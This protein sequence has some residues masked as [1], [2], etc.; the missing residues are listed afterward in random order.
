MLEVLNVINSSFLACSDWFVRIFTA[1]SMTEVY[2]VA[3]FI[4]FGIRFLLRPIFGTSRG[5]DRARNSS[6]VNDV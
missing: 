1:S 2:I 5:S 6:E 3:I 4:I